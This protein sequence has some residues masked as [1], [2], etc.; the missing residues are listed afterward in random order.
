MA[1]TTSDNPTSPR[2]NPWA[3]IPLLYFMQAIPVTR[4][5]EVAA[6]IFKD[7]GVANEPITRWTSIIALPWSMQLLLG[8]LIDLTHTKRRWILVTQLGMVF[9]LALLPFALQLAN[10]FD[11]S[12]AILF[13]SAVFSALCNTATDGF[14]LVSMPKEQ[15]AAF[16]G[17]QTTFYRLG[18][19]FC[20]GI[21]VL[22]V[23]WLSKP[24]TFDVTV[25]K[26]YLAFQKD[27][28]ILFRSKATLKVV[29]AK[30]SD[31]DGNPLVPEVLVGP[32]TKQIKLGIYGG[33][34]FNGAEQQ[35][36]QITFASLPA[37]ELKADK[38]GFVAKMK[39]NQVQSATGLTDE[40]AGNY[41]MSLRTGWMIATL[42][43]AAL[44][45]LGYFA[46]LRTVPHP[47]QDVPSADSSPAERRKNTIRTF[48]VLGVGISG[49][50]AVSGLWKTILHVVGSALG[51]AAGKF[52][53]WVLPDQASFAGFASPFGGIMAEVGQAAICGAIFTILWFAVKRNVIGTPMGDA[54]GSF[55]KQ[56][57][58]IAILS[59]LLFYRFGE[60]MVSKMSP[61]FLKDSPSNGGLGIPNEV[62]GQ[63]KG[64]VGVLGIVLGGI[65]GGWFVSKRGLKRS[66]W[67]LAIVMHTPNLLYLWAAITKPH[68]SA[69]YFVDFI[70][71]F[72][73]GFGFAG[74]FIILQHIARRGN[75]PTSHYAIGTGIGALVITIAGVLS[76]IIQSNLG[77]VWFFASVILLTI[78]GMITLL[79]LP[80]TDEQ[81]A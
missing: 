37:G 44:Y 28:T 42:V 55:F 77:Y 65:A 56:S 23:G 13:V 31:S 53:G 63:I 76:G 11:V 19:L 79:Y 40:V 75:F 29:A 36:K 47:A 18:R 72:G 66:F 70:D 4:V 38:D 32:D 27:D 26:A 48:A 1:A 58:I 64:V 17:I 9:G 34:S 59:F 57:G 68:A 5:Q 62:L 54:F 67:P 3:F 25:R 69:I 24:P 43:C 49:Y 20:T 21:L 8:P 35:S 15:Q 30:L 71:Q 52:K 46:N 12:L 10:A 7:L 81:A 51:G 41:N 45:A 73:Y 6:V 33:L 50:F 74:Y 61:L 78:P 14:Y 60:V 80:V 2:L 16:A 22:I 39:P